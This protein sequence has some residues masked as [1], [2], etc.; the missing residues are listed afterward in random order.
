[1]GV[2]GPGLV[3]VL[4]LAGSQ[5]HADVAVDWANGLITADGFGV[6]DRHAPSPAV[7][8]GTSRR[9]A[10]DA[11]RRAIRA[12]VLD[13]PMAAGGKVGDRA[14]DRAVQARIDRAVQRA[15]AIAA[16][17]ETDGSWRVT[18]AVPIEAVRQALTAART[19]PEH[20]DSGPPVVVVEGAHAAPA[21]GWKIGGIDAATVW[22]TE[23]PAYARSAPR[24]HGEAKAGEVAVDG[25]QGSASTLFVMLR[26]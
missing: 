6:A 15:F 4:A 20:G 1:M 17:P 14:A 23:I 21:V 22:V 19:L 11:A 10:E 26:K 2:N 5:A 13:L 16:H 12:R 24:V 25:M 18:M 8:R 7:A 9:P 3:A